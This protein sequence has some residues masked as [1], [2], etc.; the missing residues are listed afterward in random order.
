MGGGVA[1]NSELRR[2]FKERIKNEADRE[3]TRFKSEAQKTLG[4]NIDAYLKKLEEQAGIFQLAFKDQINDFVVDVD[5]I[6]EL[7]QKEFAPALLEKIK[8]VLENSDLVKFAKMT[9]KRLLADELV[10]Q[11]I[12]I[13]DMSKLI[14]EVNKS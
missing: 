14:T 12:Q 2:Q 8:S 13:V 11:L 3:V 9:P 10:A 5:G 7:K 1:A 4:G 6:Y